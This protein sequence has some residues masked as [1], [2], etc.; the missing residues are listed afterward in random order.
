MPAATYDPSSTPGFSCSLFGHKVPFDHAT[1]LTLYPDHGGYARAVIA[2]TETLVREG[3]LTV[4]DA[5]QIIDEAAN[6][7][8][9]N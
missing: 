1:L 6:S 2:D 4:P 9:P 5:Q 3:F 7:S 8:I